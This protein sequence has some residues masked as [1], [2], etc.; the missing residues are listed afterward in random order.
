MRK[1]CE[2]FEI[3]KTHES[4]SYLIFNPLISHLNKT[5]F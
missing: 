2:N 3:V 5:L 1:N 4:D